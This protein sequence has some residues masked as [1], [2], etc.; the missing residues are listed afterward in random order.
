M[1]TGREAMYVTHGN[2]NKVQCW[3]LTNTV[4]NLWVPDQVNLLVPVNVTKDEQHPL[5]DCWLVK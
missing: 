1:E 4:M 5:S 2:R 3:S